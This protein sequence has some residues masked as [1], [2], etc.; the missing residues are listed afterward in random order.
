M[1]PELSLA[2]ATMIRPSL[3]GRRAHPDRR[4]LHDVGGVSSGSSSRNDGIKQSS[5]CCRLA[6]LSQ[7][8]GVLSVTLAWLWL[9]P[10]RARQETRVSARDHNFGRSVRPEEKPER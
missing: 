4:M 3:F 1:E 10:M 9:A 8:T 2:A 5:R 6:E 7:L